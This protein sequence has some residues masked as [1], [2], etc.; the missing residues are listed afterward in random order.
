MTVLGSCSLGLRVLFLI[1][2][3]CLSP[4][5]SSTDSAYLADEGVSLGLSLGYGQ[6]DNPV[7][8][9]DDIPLYALPRIEVFAGDFSF[10]NTQFAWTPVWGDNYQVSLFTQL[11]EDGL[12]FAKH[13]AALTA[14]RTTGG[15]PSMTP[16]PP[17]SGIETPA[18]TKRRGD[19]TKI[20]KRKLSAMS[21]I[22]AIVDWQSWRFSAYWSMELT[23]YHKGLQGALSAQRLFLFDQH[24]VLLGAEIQH[25][26]AGLVDYYYG[27]AQ[28][29]IRAGFSPFLGRSSQ[30]YNLK[31]SYQ[32]QFNQQWQ[33]ISDIKYQRLS[34]GIADSPLIDDSNLLS[35]YAGF[36]W[37]Y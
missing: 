2:A 21:G 6:L 5:A 15:R 14:I 26:S 37:N 20:S 29:E 23:N 35:F 31:A 27:S 9:K 33:F 28:Q 30:K 18:V 4:M 19:I 11:N 12:Y 34:S 32:Y 25:L 13:S 17:G 22:E 1:S 8:K 24:L 7:Y 10:A 3:F 36:A 16:P